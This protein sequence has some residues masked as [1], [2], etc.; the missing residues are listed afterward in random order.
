MSFLSKW[1]KRVE[2]VVEDHPAA[3]LSFEEALVQTGLQEFEPELSGTL[4]NSIFVYTAPAPAP[5]LPVGASRIG[6][7]PDLPEGIAWPAVD[8]EPLV[9][10]AQFDLSQ[11][12]DYDKDS[13]LP[14]EGF[15][16]FFYGDMEGSVWGFDPDDKDHWRVIFHPG[17]A[18]TLKRRN[19]PLRLPKGA[20]F[21]E[22]DVRF[23]TQLTLP[24]DISEKIKN[25]NDNYAKLLEHLGSF[26]THHQLLGH[27]SP[28]QGDV[29]LE[30]QLV[31]NGLYCGDASGYKDPRAEGL[32]DGVKDWILL[33]QVD[34]D[35]NPN[36]IWGDLGRLYFCIR[37]KDLEAR[38]FD[39]VWMILQC[40]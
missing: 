10:L 3:P 21:K 12:A 5:G 18:S 25:E 6:G 8:D 15:L 13:L 24:H 19:N 32:R 37:K 27:E 28:V 7:V 39:T 16:Y 11:V 4:A 26:T 36:M 40:S 14:A 34:S 22:C 9:F 38:Q 31:S 33:F 30:C 29:K 23:S 17:P 35:D 1:F 20:M 2:R